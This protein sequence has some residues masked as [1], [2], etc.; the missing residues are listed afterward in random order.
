MDCYDSWDTGILECGDD[1]EP[2]NADLRWEWYKQMNGHLAWKTWKE[3][4]EARAVYIRGKY[5]SDDD[6]PE[7]EPTDYPGEFPEARFTKA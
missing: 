4:E 2:M 6:I 1:D 3:K 7:L 5:L